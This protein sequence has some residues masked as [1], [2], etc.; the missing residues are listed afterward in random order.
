MKEIIKKSNQY[1]Y[2]SMRYTQ[3]EDLYESNI[4]INND[5]ILIIG[6]IE[7]DSMKIDWATNNPKLLVESMITIEKDLESNINIK[8]L[9]IEFIPEEIIELFEQNNYII[10]S[11]W[12]D[13][14]KPK[15]ESKT[16]PNNLVIRPIE[17][18][19]YIIGSNITKSCKGYSRG[20]NGE[21]IEWFKEWKD[22]EFSEIFVAEQNNQI[23]GV[24]AVNLYGFESEKGTVLWLREVA[25]H[26]KFHSQKIGFHLINHAFDW[27]VKNGAQRSFLACDRDNTKAIR[28]YEY[29][30][31]EA[32]HNR[33]QINI[34]K[35]IN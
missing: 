33:G 6:T 21:E 30:G 25:V 19:E 32:K 10:K 3:E 23:V 24:C 14:W 28:L 26:P 16:T 9:T 20:Y 17:E 2:S 5:S 27:G 22:N 7:K 34:E 29:L 8:H 12:M 18:K 1:K 31:Y 4:L 13:Y 11:E 15:L 35:F